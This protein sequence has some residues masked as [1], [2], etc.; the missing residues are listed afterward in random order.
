[1]DRERLRAQGRE[2]IGE[3]GE[4]R[5]LREFLRT[6]ELFRGLDAEGLRTV[7][8]LLRES[9][10]AT[11]EVLFRHGDPAD[12][13]YLMREG[14]VALFRDEVGKPLQLL[15]R[16]RGGEHF[17]EL[18]LLDGGE[19]QATARVTEASRILRLDRDP[20]LAFLDRC[21]EVALKLHITAA[22]RHSETAAAVLDTGSRDEVRIRIRR[23]LLLHS[24]GS[25]ARPVVLENLSRGGL[26]LRGAPAAWHPPAVVAFAL[27]LD[28]ERLELR[29]RVS[30]RSG[31]LLGIAFTDPAPD[32]DVKIQ[33]AFRRLLASATDDG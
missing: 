16:Y 32:H 3:P 12:A 28:G 7:A 27:G 24:P 11:G 13:F 4:I 18:D 31:D 14:T 9:F 23:R 30:W 22:R 5:R 33:R 25:D 8:G 17:G 15:A 21:P 1:M 19:R 6:L 10:H 20:F 2:V 26:S 29:G